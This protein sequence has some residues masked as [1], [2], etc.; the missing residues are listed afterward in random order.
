MKEN[1]SILGLEL[2][3]LLCILFFTPTQ[4]SGA[5]VWSET[6]DELDP[7]LWE[8][9]SCQII[10][11]ILRG[12]QGDHISAVRAYYR[13]NVTVGTWK[14]DL[15]EVGGW[16][17][18]LDI[19][20]IYFMS[21]EKPDYS[22]SY[23]LSLVQSS[24]PDGDSYSYT[25]E[26][27][28]NSF[29]TNL[30]NYIGEPHPLLTGMLQHLAITRDSSGLMSVYLNSTLILQV[31]DTDITTTS[32]FGFYTWDDWA[33]DNVS[34]YDTIEIGGGLPLITIGVIAAVPIAIIA[35][36]LIRRK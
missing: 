29:K 25:I 34:V 2:L 35:I 18:E 7:A 9:Y 14:F 4:V 5:L 28:Y 8:N 1:R 11:G 6:F 16:G 36:V 27:W 12:V 21:P 17:E 22:V 23:A 10:D 24:G 31:T 30:V 32:Y 3:T 26:K 13:S 33:F 19:M 15:V 20:K